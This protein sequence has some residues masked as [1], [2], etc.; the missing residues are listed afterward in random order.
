VVVGFDQSSEI[1]I[2][3]RLLFEF[4]SLVVVRHG[5]SDANSRGIISDKSVDHPLTDFGLAQA[6]KTAEV[7][8]NEEFDLLISST[9]KRA[10][11][12]GQIINEHHNVQTILS[13]DLIERDYG[14][15]SGM[16][17][18]NASKVMAAEGFGWLEIPES[19]TA[20]HIDRRVRRVISTLST[21]Y[22]GLRILIV[23]HEDIVRSFYRVLEGKSATQSM[24]LKI[25][26]SQ[27]H[28][29]LPK[30]SVTHKEC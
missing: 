28:R 25:G 2:K 9:R 4:K 24:Q 22:S 18:L 12:T 15:F 26:N 16:A 8:K 30:S 11:V 27:P 17:K 6:K 20:T 5:E 23:T 7:L 19:E 29:F 3:E 14:V 10:Q 21:N 1:K 13:E